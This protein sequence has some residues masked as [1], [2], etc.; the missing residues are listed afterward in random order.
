MITPNS[1]R[2]Q[3]AL[4]E[5]I[6]NDITNSLSSSSSIFNTPEEAPRIKHSNSFDFDLRR[7]PDKR[8]SAGDLINSYN[9]RVLPNGE[10]VACISEKR[11]S[12]NVLDEC[13]DNSLSL[14][15]K[16]RHQV[17]ADLWKDLQ[18]SEVTPQK[19]LSAL[20]ALETTL[21]TG[22]K[23][24]SAK[25]PATLDLSLPNLQPIRY[26]QRRTRPVIGKY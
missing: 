14:E 1:A 24:S 20:S 5:D 12:A 7:K 9:E 25:R 26:I 18:G 11:L 8:F 13:A 23:G 15:D 21:W 19:L 22:V 17:L 4:E 10:L 2:E 6:L 16:K 3:L